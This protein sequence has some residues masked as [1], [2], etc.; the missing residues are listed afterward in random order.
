M[1]QPNWS[2]ELKHQM[3]DGKFNASTVIP[4]FSAT[5]DYWPAP[6]PDYIGNAEHPFTFARSL[7]F[8]TNFESTSE[9]CAGESP[10]QFKENKKKMPTDWKYASKKVLYKVNSSGYRTKEWK[11]LDWKN[12]VVILGDSCTFG[13]GVDEEETISSLLE[14]KIGRPV[15][16]L[17]TPGCS[18]QQILNNCST[19]LNNFE[20]PYAVVINWSTADRFRYFFK[21]GYHDVGPWD[22]NNMIDGVDISELWKLTYVDRYN[23]LCLAYNI[24][25]TAQA[26]WKDRTKYVTISYF[27][28]VAHYT[29]ADRFFEIKNTARDL[30]HPGY[31]N[32]L[33]VSEYLKCKLEE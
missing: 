1:K 17:G 22:T 8:D 4:K 6:F 14:Q 31:E 23:E 15:I 2:K 7:H 20:V 5:G 12:S 9:W 16:N 13:V 18:N 28:Y 25:R 33:E 29:R 30:M 3:D 10:E 11:Q 19:I 32:S 27:D 24:S 26:L 21:T